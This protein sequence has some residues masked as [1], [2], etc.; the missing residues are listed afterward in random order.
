MIGNGSR[1]KAVRVCAGGP[2][3]EHASRFPGGPDIDTEL[4]L[5]ELK[6]QLQPHIYHQ[7]T[8]LQGED[9]CGLPPDVW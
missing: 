7:P 1:D 9:A 3:Y 4:R 5:T 2:G 8:I 6:D